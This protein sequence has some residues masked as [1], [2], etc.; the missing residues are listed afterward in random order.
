MA[1]RA[2]CFYVKALNGS[3]QLACVEKRKH[4]YAGWLYSKGRVAKRLPVPTGSERGSA[5]SLA[6]AV[7]NA[8]RFLR[9]Q[10]RRR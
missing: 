6:E 9:K 8:K 7:R 2:T 3:D 5:K 1:R 10:R 4:G